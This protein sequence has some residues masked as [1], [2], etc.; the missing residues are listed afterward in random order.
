MK[1]LRLNCGIICQKISM[2]QIFNKNGSILPVTLLWVDNNYIIGKREYEN[3]IGIKVASFYKKKIKISKNIFNKLIIN[4]K[5]IIKEF[6]VKKS[7]KYKLGDKINA[8]DFTI[9]QFLDITGYSIGKGFAG[10]IKRHN[11]KGLEASHGVSVSHR[12]AGS[13]G[14]CQDPGKVF[15]GK[16]MSGHLGNK[17]VTIQNLEI[18]DIDC[19]LNII[20]VKGSVPGYNKS[21]LYIRDSIKKSIN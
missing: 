9:G 2:T 12:S 1:Q 4:Y 10:V 20:V 5:K 6:R 15:K 21:Y 3:G 7:P 18:I 11:F 14:Q 8:K 17:Q 13:T 16:K 19:T